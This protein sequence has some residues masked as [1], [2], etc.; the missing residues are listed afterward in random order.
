MYNLIRVAYREGRSKCTTL[1][2]RWKKEARVLGLRFRAWAI[3]L[4]PMSVWVVVLGSLAPYR[5]ITATLN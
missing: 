3:V 2:C 4:T 1:R 5:N